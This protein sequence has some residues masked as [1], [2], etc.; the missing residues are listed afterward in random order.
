[1]YYL[2]YNFLTNNPLLY[3]VHLKQLDAKN[4]HH[5]CRI[6]A[7]EYIFG[8]NLISLK[9]KI[10]HKIIEHVKPPCVHLPITIMEQYIELIL[11]ADTIYVNKF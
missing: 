10:V 6:L 9:Y 11:S 1:M 4:F 7:V 5:F 3:Q 8:T 2:R